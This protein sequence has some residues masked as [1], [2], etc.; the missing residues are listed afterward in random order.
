MAAVCQQSVRTDI[1]QL[2]TGVRRAC[3]SSG[4]GRHPCRLLSNAVDHRPSVRN[5]R[6]LCSDIAS[7]A[8]E[9]LRTRSNSAC[10]ESYLGF[11]LDRVRWVPRSMCSK[12]G[13]RGVWHRSSSV[14]FYAIWS[15]WEEDIIREMSM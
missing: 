5:D 9:W 13:K 7:R 10:D 14:A 15:S 3:Q 4:Q 2:S 11:S 12:N 8:D 6:Y 1:A